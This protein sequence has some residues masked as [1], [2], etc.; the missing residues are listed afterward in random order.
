[1]CKVP[2]LRDNK[3]KLAHK[4][5]INKIKNMQKGKKSNKIGSEEA[6]DF[7]SDYDSDDE[8]ATTATYKSE[9]DQFVELDG[10]RIIDFSHIVKQL[11]DGRKLCE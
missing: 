10:V 7:I 6:L 11:C 4:W 2:F 5:K 9:T 8:P 3:G 1:M